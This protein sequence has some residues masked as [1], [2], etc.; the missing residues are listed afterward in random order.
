[1]NQQPNEYFTTSIDQAV[2]RQAVHTLSAQIVAALRPDE[3]VFT[4]YAF[5][6]LMNLA[7]QGE[8]APV[9]SGAKFGFGGTELLLQVVVP[10]VTSALTTLFVLANVAGLGGLDEL[11]PESNL[12]NRKEVE[13]FVRRTGV[14]LSRGEIDRIC[15]QIDQRVKLYVTVAIRA[16]GQAV[17]RDYCGYESGAL[18]DFLAAAFNIEELCNLC[19]DLGED[20]EVIFVTGEGREGHVRRL[21]EHFGRR[22]MHCDLVKRARQKRERLDWENLTPPSY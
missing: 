3:A 21:L 8:V 4:A 13:Q 1:M 5:D 16:G 2:N 19:Q 20:H 10:A 18:R 9:G 17:A 11:P 15:G 6:P 14:R 12:I 7:A 22:G